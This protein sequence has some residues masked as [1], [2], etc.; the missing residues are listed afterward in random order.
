MEQRPP[1]APVS[2]RVIVRTFSELCITAG[3]V[4]VLFVVYVLFWTGVQADRVMGDQID[5]LHDQWAQ[6]TV[7]PPPPPARA[8]PRSRRRT[9]SAGPSR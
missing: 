5:D 3:T 8:P 6:G 7:A 1:G 4:I 2:V 9:G